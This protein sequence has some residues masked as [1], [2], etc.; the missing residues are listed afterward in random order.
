MCIAERIPTFGVAVH[1]FLYLFQGELNDIMDQPL[2]SKGHIS[3][4]QRMLASIYTT[5]PRIIASRALVSV[6]MKVALSKKFVRVLVIDRLGY[7]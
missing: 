1:M 5:L 4:K 2:L 7:C 6:I 3:E